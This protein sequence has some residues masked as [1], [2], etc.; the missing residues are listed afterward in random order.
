ML[1]TTG[2]WATGRDPRRSPP[3]H[4]ANLPHTR[5]K[6]ALCIGQLTQLEALESETRAGAHVS[7]PPS[8]P[9]AEPLVSLASR[10]PNRGLLERK[11]QNTRQGACFWVA[12]CPKHRATRVPSE[13]RPQQGP[14]RKKSKGGGKPRKKEN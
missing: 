5:G 13:Q 4:T 14:T 2:F 6:V 7:G 9:N 11:L 10:G 12:K 1:R 8:A 3:K